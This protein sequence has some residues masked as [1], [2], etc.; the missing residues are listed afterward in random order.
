MLFSDCRR[1]KNWIWRAFLYQRVSK[2]TVEKQYEIIATLDIEKVAIESVDATKEIMADL[3]VEQMR[4]GFRAD[5]SPIT[6]DYSDVTIMIKKAKRQVWDHVTL[7]DTGDFQRSITVDVE[8]KNVVLDSTD[9]KTA[10]LER[11]YSKAK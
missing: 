2:M 10:K 9:W 11:K 3:N 8:G 4:A 5:G 1:W 7:Q 6:P